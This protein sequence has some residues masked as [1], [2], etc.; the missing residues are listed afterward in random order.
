MA[1]ICPKCN[2][3]V[4]ETA[5][6]CPEC[7]QELS[8]KAHN[9]AWIAGKQEEIKEARDSQKVGIV[10]IVLSVVIFG[11]LLWLGLEVLAFIG[12]AIFMVIGAGISLKEAFRLQR[13]IKELK[14]GRED[15]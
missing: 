9:P 11:V 5:K 6:F 12:G 13:L 1:R 10:L 15:K 4:N 7:G 3:Q 14:K 8:E 2:S